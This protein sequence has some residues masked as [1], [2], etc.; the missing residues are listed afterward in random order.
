MKPIPVE[1]VFQ[2]F[3]GNYTDLDPDD[4]PT[5]VLAYAV[6]QKWINATTQGKRGGIDEKVWAGTGYLRDSVTLPTGLYQAKVLDWFTGAKRG[7]NNIYDVVLLSGTSAASPTVD[8]GYLYI[9]ITNASTGALVSSN[10]YKY[11]AGGVTRKTSPTQGAIEQYLDYI[12]LVDG[13]ENKLF[14]LDISTETNVTLSSVTINSGT[15]AGFL[16]NDGFTDLD[17]HTNKLFITGSKGEV[18]YSETLLPL[19]FTDPDDAGFIVYKATSGMIANQLSTSFAG[20]VICSENTA[21]N[22]FGL[23]LM[24]GTTPFDITQASTQSRGY[25]VQNLSD[26]IA[27]IPG[28]IQNIDNNIVGLTATGVMDLA[29][30]INKYKGANQTG[31]DYALGIEDTL[32]YPI[33]DIIRDLDKSNAAV[34]SCHDPSTKRYYL[35]C[36]KTSEGDSSSYLYVYDYQYKQGLPRW[37]IWRLGITG[38]GGLFTVKNRP[39]VSDLLGNL[40]ELDTTETT[41][42]GEKYYSSIELAAIGGDSS[43]YDKQWGIVGVTIKTRPTTNPKPFSIYAIADEHLVTLTAFQE[44]KLGINLENQIKFPG[45]FDRFYPFSRTRTFDDGGRGQELYYQLRDL[46]Q[47]KTLRIIIAEDSEAIEGDNGDADN[48]ITYWELKRVHVSGSILSEAAQ[49]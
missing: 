28:S 14:Y 26:D 3:K 22:Q 18:Y 45:V 13:S 11:D 34:Y 38:I 42:A 31:S 17:V 47:S 9:E 29:T 49:N 35:S 24:T 12:L 48:Y 39:Y 2:N 7:G 5:D 6:N 32:S 36:P 46:P 37:S 41:D 1:Q 19:D 4:L 23:D 27:F 30:L 15:H 40:Y 21:L 33:G 20:L 16:D 44:S 10:L 25:A 43:N 8:I